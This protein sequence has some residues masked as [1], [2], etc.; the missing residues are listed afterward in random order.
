[1]Q[2]LQLETHLRRAVINDEFNLVYQPLVE[3]ETGNVVG[4]RSADP[5]EQPPARRNAPRPLHQ[6]RR[7]HG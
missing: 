1:L 6:P 2:R 3:I 5:L 4:R 7:D